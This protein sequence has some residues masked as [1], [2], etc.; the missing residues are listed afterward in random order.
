MTAI[1][2]EN[3]ASR[4]VLLPEEGG[5]LAS[6]HIG[7]QPMLRAAVNAPG[8]VRGPLDMASFPLVPYSNRIDAARFSWDEAERVVTP[9][10]A[11][12]P[13]AIHGVGWTRPWTVAAHGPDAATLR[14]THQP[15]AHWPWAFTA[16]QQISVSGTGLWLNLSARNDADRAVPLAFGH[17]PYFDI[18]GARLCFD[19][20]CV[21]PNHEGGTPHTPGPPTGLFDFSTAG[22][23]I[24]RMMDHCFSGWPGVAHIAWDRRPHALRIEATSSLPCVVVYIPDGGEAFCFEPV[25]HINFALNTRPEAFGVPVVAPGATFEASILF[26]AAYP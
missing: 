2:L 8:A 6:W 7:D 15:D 18:D 23:V 19:A 3:G 17:H 25:P 4:A 24:G 1:C 20:A 22:L 21:W 16:E 9:N 26:E 5:A 14:Y 10:F 11:P 12:E 13:H